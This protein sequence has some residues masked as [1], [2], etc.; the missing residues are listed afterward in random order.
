M[1]DAAHE[2]NTTRSLTEELN[3][4]FGYRA[5]KSDLQERAV[6]SVSTGKLVNFELNT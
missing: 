1:S 4:V 2:E 3:E 6:T 5:F